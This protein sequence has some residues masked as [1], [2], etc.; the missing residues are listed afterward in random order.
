MQTASPAQ[1]PSTSENDDFCIAIEVDHEDGGSEKAVSAATT[2]PATP[3]RPLPAKEREH[4]AALKRHKRFNAIV[5]A[6]R[7]YQPKSGR[8]PKVSELRQAQIPPRMLA[9]CEAKE[10]RVMK[11]RWDPFILT[12]DQ[13]TF[14]SCS[15]LPRRS[16]RFPPRYPSLLAHR[17]LPLQRRSRPPVSSQLL[18]LPGRGAGTAPG[19]RKRR[20]AGRPLS[21]YKIGGSL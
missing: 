11:S 13:S 1:R 7:E 14:V 10:L 3:S 8:E 4:R 17:H 18:L 2:N 19:P 15:S 9:K 20:A 5:D 12:E 21:R 6:Y 16:R